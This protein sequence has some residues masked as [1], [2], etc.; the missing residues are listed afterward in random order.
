MATAES[1]VCGL[2]AKPYSVIAS[3]MM[4]TKAA[5]SESHR[6]LLVSLPSE[7]CNDSDEQHARDVFATGAHDREP[8][9]CKKPPP[10]MPPMP[11]DKAPTTPMSAVALEPAAGTPRAAVQLIDA[12]L[13]LDIRQCPIGFLWATRW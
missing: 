11:I 5:S 2:A 10:M 7:Q 4:H 12:T 8:E 3:A 9:G 13:R 1:R 6:Q